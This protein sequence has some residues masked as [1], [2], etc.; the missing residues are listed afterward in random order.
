[1]RS[2]PGRDDVLAGAPAMRRARRAARGARRAARRRLRRRGRRRQTVTVAADDHDARRGRR[3]RRRRRARR[4]FD[5]QAIYESEA[6]GV[7]TCLAV[8]PAASTRLGGGAAAASGWAR[9]SCQRRRRDRHER[10]RR[11]HRRG[12]RDPARRARSSSTSPTATRSRREIVGF[13]PN[14]DVALLQGRPGGPRRCAR[15]RSAPARDVTVGAPG[16]GDRLARSARR[17]RCRSASISAHR[18]LRSSRST[19]FAISGAIQTDAAINPGNSGGPL[20]DA[21]GRVI[22]INPQIKSHVAAAAGRRLRG[23]DRHRQAFARPAARDGKAHYAYLGVSLVPLYPQLA[24]QLR[25]RRSTTAP[26]SRR[27]SRAAQPTRAGLRGGGDARALPGPDRA[28][29]RHHRAVDGQPVARGG[30]PRARDRA[31]TRPGRDGRRSRSSAAA[32]RR[33]IGSSSASA[34]ASAG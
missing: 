8:Q 3:E 1:M 27:S 32:T 34:P 29:R 28:G 9:A 13:D 7:V 19:G 4:G 15:C 11:H 20:V 33:T 30:R 22:G 14:A 26:G 25:P 2:A 18:P 17:S 21:D 23:A 16:G 6:P 31:A 5:P 24:E 12:R 10:P